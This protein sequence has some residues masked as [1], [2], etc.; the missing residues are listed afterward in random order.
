MLCS[1]YGSWFVH[2]NIF[3]LL[4]YYI[5]NHICEVEEETILEL[6]W[7]DLFKKIFFIL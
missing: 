4:I 1:F 5:R 6:T 7:L 3:P 2:G